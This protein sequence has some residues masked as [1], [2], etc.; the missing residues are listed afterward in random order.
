M[1]AQAWI[2]LLTFVSVIVYSVILTIKSEKFRT[3][4]NL[5]S[6][7]MIVFFFIALFVIAVLTVFGVECSIKGS[8]S[9]RMCEY[10]SWIVTVLVVLIIIVFIIRSIIAILKKSPVTQEEQRIVVVPKT[11][12]PATPDTTTPAATTPAAT[13]P[14]TTTPA[15]TTP[16]TTTPPVTAPTTTVPPTT[17]A[18]VRR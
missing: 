1:I 11:P 6:K 13:T 9:S 14:V 3:I 7:S 10:Y 5:N 17:A 8:F 2:V 12:T 18:R 15:T 4:V 16:A